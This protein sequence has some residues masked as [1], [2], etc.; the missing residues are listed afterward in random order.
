MRVFCLSKKWGR[1][2]HNVQHKKKASKL[3]LLMLH[4]A[5]ATTLV[6]ENWELFQKSLTSAIDFIFFFDP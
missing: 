5:F 4:I 3:L 6:P 2:D 1:K